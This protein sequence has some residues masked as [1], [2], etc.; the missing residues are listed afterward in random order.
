MSEKR[1]RALGARYGFHPDHRNGFI[2]M[3]RDNGAVTRLDIFSWGGSSPRVR[4]IAR[5]ANIPRHYMVVVPGIDR[6]E[7][8][9]FM[10]PL[11]VFPDPDQ[12]V[13]PWSEVEYEFDKLYGAALKTADPDEAHQILNA[14]PKD[15]WVR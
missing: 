3:A 1:A 13:R 9:R 10:V 4:Q 8:G 7:L 5:A 6:L 14:V 2:G 11:V 15:R 12:P